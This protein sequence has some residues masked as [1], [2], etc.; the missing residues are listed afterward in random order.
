MD[1]ET[2][3]HPTPDQANVSEQQEADQE[4]TRPASAT[5]HFLEELAQK[6]EE[7]T[8]RIAVRQDTR[9]ILERMKEGVIVAI[10]VKRPRFMQRLSLEA[11]GFK[12]GR[13]QAISPAAEAVLTGYFHLG[14]RTLLPKDYQDKLNAAESSARY[15]LNKFAIP[16]HWGLFVPVTVYST[17]KQE[18]A[19]HA[20]KFWEA[21]KDIREHY[22]EICT[23]VVADYRTFAE[24]AWARLEVG[25]S[26][27]Q[28]GAADLPEPVLMDLH[29]RLHVE[30]GKSAFIE[31]YL[32]VIRQALP[33]PLLL[34]DAFEFQVELTAIPLPTILAEDLSAAEQLVA[35]RAIKDATA[36]AAL[37]HIE[38]ERR[39][40]E[41]RAQAELE[42]IERKRQAELRKLTLVE[43]E[44]RRRLWQHQQ[45]DDERRR[46]QRQ[47]EADVLTS[48]RTEKQRLLNQF[49][50]DVTAHLNTLMLETTQ[51]VLD[52]LEEHHGIL[53]GPISVQLR[54]FLES[55][56]A[57]N[58]VGDERIETQLERLR[59]VL[60]TAQ[61]SEQAKKGVEKI[62]TEPL[63]RVVS[64][65]HREA[66]Q[67]LFDLGIQAP[68][69][70]TRARPAL[71][72]IAVPDLAGQERKGRPGL[73]LPQPQR[74][75]ANARNQ[76]T[77]RSL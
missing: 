38:A 67:I 25:S 13:V 30:E 56:E 45:A 72:A 11:L 59:L 54:Q 35:E 48:A 76:R 10:H 55:L 77:P 7:D 57:L 17:W 22:E 49:Y 8:D 31:E 14:R 18:H 20:A 33:A 47:M 69:R 70:S 60:P 51:H 39:L 29:T 9:F 24:D 68:T 65:L 41:R 2:Q 37:E 46:L 3:L 53:R 62:N 27:L 43:Q 64:E 16:S 26:L 28:E 42:K 52:S 75:R 44:E 15:T 40:A 23:Q 50:N 36:R 34:A 71:E 58:F 19:R 4:E 6:L 74:K 1:Q 21:V 12:S 73:S 61:E 63:K 5:E 66:N 32:E